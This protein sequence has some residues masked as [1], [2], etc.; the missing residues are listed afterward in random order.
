MS[1]VANC[2]CGERYDLKDEFA[3]Q[4]VQCPKCGRQFQ[5][6]TANPLLLGDPAFDRD[7]FLLRQKHLSLSEKYFVWDEQGNTLLYI[8]RPAHLLRQL[9]AA[10]GGALAA[11]LVL[12]VGLMA[13]IAIGENGNSTLE[14][15]TIL[16]TL[17][18]AGLAAML[19]GCISAISGSAAYSWYGSPTRCSPGSSRLS[20]TTGPIL[21]ARSAARRR[22][23][24]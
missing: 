12:S 3:C 16:V 23:S 6:G 9:I 11:I 15:I 1:I 2:S 7:K 5:A 4:L 10:F 14:V 24:P 18:G 8:L 17:V 22:R 19:A 20:L 13:G 21:A